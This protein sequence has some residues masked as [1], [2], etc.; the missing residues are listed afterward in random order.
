MNVHSLL[1]SRLVTVPA[2]LIAGLFVVGGMVTTVEP[3]TGD[4]PVAA[5][6]TLSFVVLVVIG[7]VLG[8]VFGGNRR[9]TTYW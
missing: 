9:S 7:A 5:A 3:L 8:G 6:L 1:S 2:I 4:R